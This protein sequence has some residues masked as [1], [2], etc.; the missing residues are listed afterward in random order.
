MTGIG[1][2]FNDACESESYSNTSHRGE[3][4]YEPKACIPNTQN[5]YNR[6]QHTN[7]TEHG[8]LG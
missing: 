1:G 8:R 7:R 5:D 6:L 4:D 2:A 3:T